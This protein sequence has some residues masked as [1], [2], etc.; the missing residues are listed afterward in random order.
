MVDSLETADP[1]EIADLHVHSRESAEVKDMMGGKTPEEILD[2]IAGP[3]EFTRRTFQG[4]EVKVKAIAFTEHDTIVDK[5]RMQSI[6]AY[7]RKKDILVIPAVELDCTH[8]YLNQIHIN[9]L[10]FFDSLNR[11]LQNERF[12]EILETTK[13][14]RR[15][16][17]A[18]TIAELI[19]H[20]YISPDAK[21]VPVED[22]P[23]LYK[24]LS[25]PSL[26]SIAAFFENIKSMKRWIT[27]EGY[28]RERAKPGA[29]EIAALAHK[30]GFIFSIEHSRK[31]N[32]TRNTSTDGFITERDRIELIKQLSPRA[33]QVYYPYYEDPEFC[34][35]KGIDREVTLLWEESENQ[36]LQNCSGELTIPIGG[37][38]FH[39]V[40]GTRN[41]RRIAERF[42]L[43]KDLALLIDLY[44][45]MK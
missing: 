3:R 18:H 16:S 38:D 45:K 13:T 33:L 44:T 24:I 17:C 36:R 20:D 10:F 25:D 30:A 2:D 4:R 7:G 39:S 5:G 21:E 31:I 15:K 43:M 11:A 8:D 32:D 27:A 37:S 40:R 22:M 34:K 28:Y 29:D 42:T 1:L 9:C 35:A 41:A 26:S 12:A 6:I 19:R 14:G 23:G